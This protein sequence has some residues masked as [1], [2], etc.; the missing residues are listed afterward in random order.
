MLICFCMCLIINNYN[1]MKIKGLALFLVCAFSVTNAWAQEKWSLEKCIEYAYENNLQ[2]QQ[3]RLLTIQQSNNLLQSKMNFAPSISASISH[4]MNW[5][6]SVNVQD[7]TI[8]ENKLSQSTSASAGAQLTIFEGLRKIN[9]LK[10]AGNELKISEQETERIKNELYISITKAYLQVLLAKQIKETANENYKSTL[11][12]V[13]RTKKLVDAGS[14]AYSTLLEIQSQLATDRMQMVTADNDVRSNMLTL[15]QALDLPPSSNFDIQEPEIDAL[16]LIPYNFSDINSTYNNALKLPQI[17]TAELNLESSK[18]KY[19]IQK[20]AALPSLNLSAGYGTYY[21]DSRENA[22]FS[23]FN[24]NKNPS[25]GFSLSIPIFNGWRSNTAIRNARLNVKSTEIEL[26]KKQQSLYKE[27]QTVFNE[28]YS[29]YERYKAA[30]QNM[31]A[32]KE[33]F[34]YTEQKFNLGML[35]GTDYTVAKTKLFKAQ[36]DFFQ[37]KFQYIFQLKILDFYNK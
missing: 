36:S 32:N 5:G 19:K 16:L 6:K 20:G 30:E 31:K 1:Q 15:A 13:E 2:I 24:D 26:K 4:S 11:E 12:Q 3:Q 10:N 17:K 22:F 18:L 7:L 23:Q 25:L 14:Q 28:A 35:N 27:I 8:I 29:S 37:S 9:E 33:S 21:S 34:S